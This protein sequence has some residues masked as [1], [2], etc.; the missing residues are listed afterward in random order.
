MSEVHCATGPGTAP[1][2][3]EW[4]LTRTI[5]VG[6]SSGTI[7]EGPLRDPVL[8]A[9]W[10]VGRLPEQGPKTKEK[11]YSLHDHE[12]GCISRG[13]ARVRYEFGTRVSL[14]TTTEGGFIVDARSFPG[15][16]HDG[17]R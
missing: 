8:A 11:S 5:E 2:G 4:L 3:V 10:L 13:K 7:P 17:R 9:L 16:P 14:A 1:S 12:V 15:N 6:R